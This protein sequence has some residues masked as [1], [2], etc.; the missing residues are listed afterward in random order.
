MAKELTTEELLAKIAAQDLELSQANEVVA[1]LKT[2][3]DAKKDLVA[4]VMVK[5]GKST[6]K[7]STGKFIVPAGDQAS[8]GTVVTAEEAAKDKDL[9]TS[10]VERGSGILIEVK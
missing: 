10:L 1:E 6:Y 2:Q 8:A 3:V 5:H 9:I 4:P 7:F